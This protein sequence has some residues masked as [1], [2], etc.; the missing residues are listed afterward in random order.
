MRKISLIFAVLC[1]AASGLFAQN[2]NLP[3]V[4]F[5]FR[6]K[7]DNME[8]RFQEVAGINTEAQK[9][10]YRGGNSKVYSTVKMPGIQKSSN[11]TFKKGIVP[12][13]KKIMDYLGQIK[14]NTITRSNITV[15]L[16]DEQNNA[17]MTWILAN[18]WIV[19]I[20]GTDVKSEGNEISIESM[21]IVH[22]GISLKK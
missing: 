4:H 20:S 14:M 8:L 11:A 22:E 10:E 16:L 5:Q 19:K 1:I 21:E 13:S 15:E 17:T 2:N 3:L 9:I 18:A 6:V 12:N 7:I